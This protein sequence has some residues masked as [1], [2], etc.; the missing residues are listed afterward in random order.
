VEPYLLQLGYIQRTPRGRVAT[1]LA[2][3]A[4]GQTAAQGAA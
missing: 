1:P 3:K 2:M 4:F